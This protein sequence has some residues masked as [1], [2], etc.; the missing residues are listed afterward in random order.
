MDIL[1]SSTI[2]SFFLGV[3]L[4][5]S[6]GF[7]VFVPL[8]VLS[9]ASH[10]GAD[11]L[12]LSQQWQ[13]VGSWPAMITLS[14]ATVIE[15]LAYYIPFVDNLLDTISVPLSMVAGTLLMAA[16]LTDMNEVFTWTLAIIAGGGIAGAIGVG[17]AATRAASSG[18]T[19]GF[20]N[21][22]VNSGETATASVL[23]ITSI[24]WTP[25][26]IV[27]VILSIISIYFLWKKT[28]KMVFNK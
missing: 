27:L 6:A 15:V 20:G 2:I 10:F 12:S 7:R 23:S 14:A 16:T 28:K 3:G 4:A 21:F 18:T 9:I 19:G 13:W 11:I 5:A 1:N 17:T 25:V 8:F 24:F 22:I 26:A